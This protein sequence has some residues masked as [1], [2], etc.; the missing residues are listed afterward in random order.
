MGRWSKVKILGCGCG[1]LVGVASAITAQETAANF[2]SR[3]ITLVVPQQ[4][5]SNPDIVARLIAMPLQDR[6]GKAVVVENRPGA[7]ASLGASGVA[8]AAPDGYT[9]LF[10]DLT[11][12]VA[13]SIIAKPG[14]DPVNSFA[15][16]ILAARSWLILTVNPA[17]PARTLSELIALAKAKPGDLKY[18]SPGVGSPPHLA[19]L[20][21][22]DSTGVNILH[23]PYRGSPAA[24]TDVVGGHIHMIFN[25]Q[26][27]VI[28]QIESGALRVLAVSGPARFPKLPDVP[29]FR[30]SG[31][32]VK[33]VEEGAWFGIVV[34]AG[35]PS[36]I[37]GKL[38]REINSV[39]NEADTRQKLERDYNVEGGPP[40]VFGKIIAQ[41]TSSW[42]EALS[43]AGVKP[44]A[45]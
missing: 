6:L 35:T 42:A 45:Q 11:V 23:V 41:Q 24:I 39:L 4:A 7:S 2:P 31:V 15:P 14:F 34:P 5:G 38:N 26:G 21:F 17:L 22:L 1:L 33:G 25:S 32:D 8:K 37:V 18:G 29:T 43:R 9:M 36:E 10:T 20:T 44:A 3:N 19:A 30:E 40:E 12:A 28:S 16:V 13:P 27:A